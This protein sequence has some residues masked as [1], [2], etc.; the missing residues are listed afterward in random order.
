M[1]PFRLTET[2]PG[3]FSL[4]LTDFDGAAAAF[5]D[6]GHEAGG[7]GWETIARQ[8]IEDQPALE[9]LIDFDSES[10]M[11]CAYGADKAA[12]EQLAAALSTLFHNNKPLKAIIARIPEDGWDD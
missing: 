11:F 7:Y 10:S 6:A 2:E 4:L 5:E 9:P 1:N 8:V 3:K 12:L